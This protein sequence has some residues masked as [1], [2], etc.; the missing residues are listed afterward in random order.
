MR[1]RVHVFTYDC[2]A[3]LQATLTTMG[4]RLPCACCVCASLQCCLIQWCCHNPLTHCRCMT[5]LLQ[6][7]RRPTPA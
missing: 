3:K 1:E 5:R 2:A 6:L 7:C 4:F